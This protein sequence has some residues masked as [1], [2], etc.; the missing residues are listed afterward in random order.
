MRI[1]TAEI[2]ASLAQFQGV[3]DALMVHLHDGDTDE[4]VLFIES[5]ENLN[6]KELKT[7][8]RNTCSPRHVPD[9][10]CNVPEIPYTISGKKVEIPIKRLLQGEKL[11]DVISLDALKNPNA[12][13]WFLKFS[14]PI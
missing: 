3:N 7:H 14:S 11:Q 1:G 12:I 5:N 6:F 13:D 2:Y 10:I 9:Q 8:I 4:L